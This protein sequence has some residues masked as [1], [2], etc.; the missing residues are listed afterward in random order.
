MRM[1]V[2]GFASNIHEKNYYEK[3]YSEVMS[4]MNSFKYV[5]VVDEIYTSVP[6]ISLDKYDLIIAVH[7][8]GATSGLVYKTVI[9]YNKPVLLIAND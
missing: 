8:T 7:L 4:V 2:M 5:D 1:I 9:P 6:S 3:L